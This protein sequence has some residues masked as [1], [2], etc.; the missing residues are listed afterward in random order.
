M[1]AVV[2]AAST[3]TTAGANPIQVTSEGG[4]HPTLSP[5]GTWIAFDLPGPGIGRIAAAG[6]AV[7]TLATIGREPDWSR[8]A[9][10]RI[11]I[12]Q[13]LT[14]HV[15]DVD[16]GTTTPLV[17][18]GFDD[19][20][21]WSPDGSEIAVEGSLL[22]VSYPGGVITAIACTDPDATNCQGEF[23][24]WSPDGQSIAFENGSDLLRVGRSGGVASV[25][26]SDGLD[27]TD[28]A[29]SPD[30]DWIAFARN[31]DIWIVS[32][33]GPAGGL[34]QLTNDPEFDSEAAWSP[35]SHTVY[36]TSD[37]SGREEIWKA[38]FTPTAAAPVTWSHVKSLFR[39]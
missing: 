29:W 34:A 5:D 24:T 9:S 13:D 31:G 26:L 11:V 16:A 38:A 28:P 19:N 20:P 7:D 2:I 3:T 14:L 39:R 23:P 4:S 35:D 22:V 6:S 1:S 10:N 17:T 25:V 37:R 33:Q 15:I 36:F 32:A 30:G 18:G 21:A 27:V 8:A 12:R